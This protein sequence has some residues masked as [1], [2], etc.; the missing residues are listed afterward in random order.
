MFSQVVAVEY[1][2]KGCWSVGFVTGEGLR[3]IAETE[4]QEFLTVLVS[5]CP[6]PITGPIVFVPKDEVIMLDM[7][8]EEAVRFVVSGGVV[9]PDDRRP[10]ALPA[11]PVEQEN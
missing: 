1:P 2:R 5:T 8:V 9:T 11:A 3:K 10:S 6:T 4:Q 7:T